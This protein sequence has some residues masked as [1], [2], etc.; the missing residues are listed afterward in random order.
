[1]A[2]ATVLKT[3]EGNLVRVRLPSS[4]PNPPRLKSGGIFLWCAA[5]RCNGTPKTRKEPVN[6][7][8]SQTNN[9]MS[10]IP[11]GYSGKST[12]SMTWITPLL[13]AMSVMM[14]WTVLFKYTL[15]SMTEMAIDL[16]A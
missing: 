9:A 14:T 1:M 6:R 3:V 15:P 8:L 7:L 2:D 13:V 11:T 10:T 16:P 4:A 12:V 5:T